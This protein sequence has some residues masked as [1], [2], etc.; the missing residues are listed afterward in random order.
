MRLLLPFLMLL[1]AFPAASATGSVWLRSE[2]QAFAQ[3]RE[4]ERFVLLYLEAV[5]CHWCHVM[6]HQT[7]ANDEVRGV[8]AGHY[9]PLR[10]DQDARPDLANRYRDYGWPAT[11]VFASDGSEIVKRRGYVPPMAMARLLRAIV[12][13]PSPEQLAGPEP[14]PAHTATLDEATRTTLRKRHAD[15]YDTRLGGLDTGQKYL[16]RDSVEYALVLAADGDEREAARARQTLDA[17]QALLDPAWGG[18]YQYSTQGDWQHPHF[19]K[20]ATLQGEYLRSYSLAYAQSGEARD[21]AGADAIRRYI[22]AFLRA[23]DGGYYAS[24]DADLTPGVHSAGYYALDDAGRRAQ[25]MPRIDRHRYARETGSIAEGL[26][27]YF[28]ATGERAALDAAEA[29]I[30]WARRERSFPGGGFRHDDDAAAAPYLSDTL[31][32]ARAL[33]QSYRNGAGVDRLEAA[34]RAL[35]FIDATF[36]SDRGYVSGVPGRSPIAPV[37]QIDENISLGRFA[38]LLSHYTGKPAHRTI[39]ERALAWLAR[40]EVALSRLTEAGILLLDRELAG[41]PL[42]LTVVGSRSDP[43]AAAL[44]AAMLRVGAG[45][46]RVEWWDRALGPLPNPDVQYPPLKRAAAFVCTDRR[47][48]VPLYEPDAIPSFLAESREAARG[49]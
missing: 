11:I 1:L 27:A 8:L 23:P 18:V 12:D 44:H 5:W 28:E 10:I 33:L 6:D 49:S 29:A 41:A 19:E 36:R 46:K 21:R 37:A 32:M 17:A 42:H 47:C 14:A 30:D 22:D 7:Y 3:A 25:G 9:V 40:P 34:A 43:R 2:Q 39:A 26:G 35:E 24:Q 31:A 15:T 48:S 4:Q 38:N 13:D 16:E 45:Y 20:L